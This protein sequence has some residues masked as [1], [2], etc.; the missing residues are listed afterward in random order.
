MSWPTGGEGEGAAQPQE[1]PEGGHLQGA[2]PQSPQGHQHH[3]QSQLHL[4]PPQTHLR[5]AQRFVFLL[6][7]ILT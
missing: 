6:F 4:L 5:T 7:L 1:V 3:G 2:G